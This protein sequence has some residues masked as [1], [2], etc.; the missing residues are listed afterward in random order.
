MIISMPA[1]STTSARQRVSP[2]APSV[3]LISI[4][5]RSRVTRKEPYQIIPFGTIFYGTVAGARGARRRGGLS[6][7]GGVASRPSTRRVRLSRN[8][9]R[10]RSGSEASTSE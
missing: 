4:S 3:S 7:S 1:H 6:H 9:S 10:W 8:G 5:S 2:T